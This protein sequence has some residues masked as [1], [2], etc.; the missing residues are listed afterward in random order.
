MPLAEVLAFFTWTK[1]QADSL[2]LCHAFL[3][4]PALEIMK[5]EIIQ[6]LLWQ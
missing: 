2:G 6:L 3:A 4:V 1:P 5:L